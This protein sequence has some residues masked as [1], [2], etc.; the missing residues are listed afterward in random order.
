MR[1]LFGAPFAARTWREYAYAL[2]AT[3]FAVPAFVLVGVLGIVASVGTL[4]MVGLPVLIGVLVLARASVRWHRIPARA[5]LGWDWPSPPPRRRRSYVAV[6][7]DGVAWRALLYALA[8]FPLVV[9]AAYLGGVLVVSGTLFLTYPLWWLVVPDA[10]G[11]VDDATWAQTLWPSVQGF[12]AVMTFPWLVRLLVGVDRVLVRVLLE[13]G[14]ERRRIAALETG[15]DVLTA[16]AARTLR[17]VERDLHDGTQARLVSLGVTLSRIEQRVD[18]PAVAGLVTA[19]Q[20]TVTEALAE[21]RDIVR[22]I[23]P[24]AL[25]A[26]LATALETL[27]ARN[28]VPTTLAV[29]LPVAPSDATATAAYF[30]VAELLANVTRHASATR[31]EVRVRG[32]GDGLR[33]VVRDDGR[34]GAAVGTGSGLRGLAERARA[35]DGTFAIDSPA[36]GPTAITM[37]LGR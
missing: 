16:D 8:H 12:A 13:P 24:P 2:L 11:L 28:A 29:D 25:D 35:L 5:V 36:G 34:G 19:A 31:A 9:T 6:L 14:G 18:D 20:E 15:R 27:A 1:R 7:G 33:L 26:G 17:R 21:L 30:A 32:D 3:L 10:F 23:H 4:V 37:T 22:R